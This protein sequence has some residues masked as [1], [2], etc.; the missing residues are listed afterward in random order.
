MK[1]THGLFALFLS[2]TTVLTAQKK[3]ITLEDIWGGTFRQERMEA[4]QSLNNG[5]EY[6]VL[7]FDRSVGTSSIDVYSYKTGEKTRT[8]L[9]S[10]DLE[11][12]RAFSGYE[13]SENENKLVLGYRDRTY[14]QAF[15]P[16]NFLR[17]R[18][19]KRRAEKDFR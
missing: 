16:R 17:V 10:K 18:P 3:E 1:L 11:E 4:L 2:A 6:V 15:H 13:F 12:I 19:A 5:K 14:L 7:N 9:N 8:I